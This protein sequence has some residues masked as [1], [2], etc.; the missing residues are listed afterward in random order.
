MAERYVNCKGLQCPGPLVQVAREARGAATGDI[1]VV[2][3]TDIGFKKDVAA[4]AGKT[5]NEL[6]TLEE[7]DG[8]ITVR[9]R[10]SR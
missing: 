5:G 1:L 2:E 7:A 10:V 6:L 4:W 3:A 9:I 8:V